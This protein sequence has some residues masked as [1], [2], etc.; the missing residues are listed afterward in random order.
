M[1]TEMIVALDVPSLSVMREKVALLGD[2]V[3]YYKVGLELFTQEGPAT[4]DVLKDAGK[5]VFLD[6]KLH[7]IPRTVARAVAAAARQGADMLTVHASGGP[8]MLA[9]AAAAAREAGE[10]RPSIV[11]VTALTSLDQ[12][13]LQRIGVE[14]ALDDHVLKLADMA[15]G[16]G[17]DGLVCSPLELSALRIRLGTAPILVAPGV[18]PAG[19]D[20]GDQ[21]RMATP[22]SAARDGASFIVVGRPVLDTIDPVASAQ[23]IREELAVA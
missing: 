13:D 16:E 23:A 18:R 1:K 22:A 20:A 8:G 7:D 14:R 3:S 6:L 4:L 21:K 11:A 9:A 19:T 17:V 12:Q 5:R 2:A 15:T 10:A